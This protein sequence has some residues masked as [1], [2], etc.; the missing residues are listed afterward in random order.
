[1]ESAIDMKKLRKNFGEVRAV[2]D[3]SLKIK[4]GELFGLLGPNGAGKTTLLKILTAQLRPDSGTAKVMGI[5]VE[6]EPI[7]IK[8][9]IGVVPEVVLLPSFLTIKEYLD[10]IAD[11][12]K[13]ETT[14]Y[15]KWMEFMGIDEKQNYLC[16]DLSRGERER[17]M[18]CAA[19]MHKPRILFLDEP[20]MGLD[21]LA[22]DNLRKFF[23]DYMKS[24]GT[25]FL[26]TH[27]IDLAQRL[28][29]KV[30]IIKSGKLISVKKPSKNLEKL[31][32]KKTGE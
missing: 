8:K 16:K 14:S 5:D 2:K 27:S 19:F 15:E 32:L 12:R 7:E 26:C 21:P 9:M 31:F 29:S 18:L 25:I 3:I 10:F 28:C 4:K 1:M 20:M 6:N 22:Q 30:G 17:V 13:L 11:V 23:K 24:G